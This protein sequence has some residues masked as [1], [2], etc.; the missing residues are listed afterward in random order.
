MTDSD[1]FGC[2]QLEFRFYQ[3]LK[4]CVNW[5]SKVT[6]SKSNKICLQQVLSIVETAYESIED[7]HKKRFAGAFGTENHVH[8][9]ELKENWPA[10]AVGTMKRKWRIFFEKQ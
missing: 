6:Q 8:E 9:T 10:S 2:L 5:R 4:K 3:K 1:L 7:F